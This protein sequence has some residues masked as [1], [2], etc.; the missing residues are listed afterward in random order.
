MTLTKQKTKNK[1]FTRFLGKNLCDFF[2]EMDKINKNSTFYGLGLDCIKA[3]FSLFDFRIT[4]EMI[5]SHQRTRTTIGW[6]L[7]S[8]QATWSSIL[9][10]ITW[11]S[12]RYGPRNRQMSGVPDCNPNLTLSRMFHRAITGYWD[13]KQTAAQ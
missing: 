8:V 3:D 11:Q 5:R 7:K 6:S 4:L 1:N 13:R 2:N 12:F 9:Q 10:G